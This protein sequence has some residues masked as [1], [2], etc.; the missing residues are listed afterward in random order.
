MHKKLIK[1]IK[2]EEK[3]LKSWYEKGNCEDLLTEEYIYGRIEG[4]KL[5][6]KA[7][8]GV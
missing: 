4:L 8:K 2:N 3:K 5:A 7:L 1:L 6:L